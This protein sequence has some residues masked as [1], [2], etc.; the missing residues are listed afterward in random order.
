M[1]APIL[2]GRDALVRYSPSYVPDNFTPAFG[3]APPEEEESLKSLW[4]VLRKRKVWIGLVT[5]GTL[6]L[7]ALVC[8]FLPTQYTGM[9]TIRVGKGESSDPNVMNGPVT[10]SAQDDL[11]TEMATPMGIL[12]DDSVA[13]AVIKDLSLQKYPPFR[14][15]PSILGWI[16]GENARIKAEAG[17]PLSQAPATRER[18]LLK[19]SKKLDVENVPDTR[20]ITVAFL[21]P[22]P[23]LAAAIANDLIRQYILFEAR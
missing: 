9:A 4:R 3:A 16:T 20:L 14:Y 11:K 17:L 5:L 21:N 22:D 12:Q 7:A 18:L 10:P 8:I 1:S 6:V 15:N 23:K 2:P 19:F 13:L